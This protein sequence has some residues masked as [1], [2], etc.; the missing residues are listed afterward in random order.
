MGD[1]NYKIFLELQK[2]NRKLINIENV[3]ESKL[4]KIIRILERIHGPSRFE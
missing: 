1:M 4:D 3:L 2:Q